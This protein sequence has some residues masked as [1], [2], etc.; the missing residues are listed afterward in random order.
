[1]RYEAGLTRPTATNATAAAAYAPRPPAAPI[2][3]ATRDKH[4]DTE[5]ATNPEEAAP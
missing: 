1:M 3:A 2:A 5:A 4:A